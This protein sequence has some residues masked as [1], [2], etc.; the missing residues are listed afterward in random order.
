[1]TGFLKYGIKAA[2]YITGISSYAMITIENDSYSVLV[3]VLNY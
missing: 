1:M 3:T 2:I